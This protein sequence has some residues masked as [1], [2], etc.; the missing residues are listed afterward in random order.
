MFQ[1]TKRFIYELPLLIIGIAIL[2]VVLVGA[3]GYLIMWPRDA[4]ERIDQ[5]FDW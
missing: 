5:L 3:L 4:K 2:F 1:K